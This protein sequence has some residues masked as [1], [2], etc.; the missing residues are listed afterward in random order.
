VL[1]EPTRIKKALLLFEDDVAG[2]AFGTHD[3]AT[4]RALLAEAE[5]R[6]ARAR[7]VGINVDDTV[8]RTAQ[9][10][11]ACNERWKQILVMVKE[12]D[13]H[14]DDAL[15][16]HLTRQQFKMRCEIVEAIDMLGDLY[17]F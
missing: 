10:A 15:L 5:E 6:A 2:A 4:A 1:T 13:L 17:D 9:L 3:I 11:R 16:E 14:P 12:G 8:A 7:Q